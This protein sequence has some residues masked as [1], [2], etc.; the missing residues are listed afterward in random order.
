M[1]SLL[2]QVLSP[3]PSP[4]GRIIIIVIII[5]GSC[6]N[7]HGRYYSTGLRVQEIFYTRISRKHS[8]EFNCRQGYFAHRMF[9][10]ENSSSASRIVSKAA[11][12]T[13]SISK[14]GSWVV[15]CCKAIFGRRRS[16]IKMQCTSIAILIFYNFYRV[17]NISNLHLKLLTRDF[18]MSTT[19]RLVEFVCA[20]DD[21]GVVVA[22]GFPVDQSLA[23]ARII[24]A[25][26]TNR[27]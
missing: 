20:N 8:P 3:V 25:D 19:A 14:S 5:K 15:R 21:N 2:R 27:L 10:K 24:S 9:Q 17:F 12:E 6:V 16:R 4:D 23:A 1:N 13:S 11:L 26:H 22:S 18:V 7:Q